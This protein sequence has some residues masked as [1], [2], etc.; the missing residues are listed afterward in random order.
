MIKKKNPHIG[1]SRGFLAPMRQYVH[2]ADRANAPSIIS[3]VLP[4]P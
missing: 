4:S 2:H 1:Q 3:M